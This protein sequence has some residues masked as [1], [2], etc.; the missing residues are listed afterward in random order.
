MLIRL[1]GGRVIDPASGRDGIGDIWIRGDRIVAPP[2]GETP[3]EVYD[4]SGKI[5]MAGAID[6]HSHVAERKCEHRPAAA[7]GKPSR[8]YR[9]APRQRRCRRRAGRLSRPAAAMPRWA[10]RPSS[11]RPFR[12]ITRC[13]RISNSPTF[14][15][16]TRA[17]LT[18]LGEDDFLLSLM[19]DGQEPHGHRGLSRRDARGKQGP[20]HQG[21]QSW[22]VGRLS[23]QCAHLR[24]RRCRAEL[25]RHIAADLRGFAAGGD[26]YRH[27]AS[28]ASSHQQSRRSPAMS[29][30]RSRPSP[31]P[32]A[33]RCISPICS[34]I[35]MARRASA[36][37][38]PRPRASRR[39]SMRLRK[40]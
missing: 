33:S 2:Q 40:R 23:E 32:A 36:A 39:R 35:P 4:V 7:A 27:S 38:L 14:R 8:P 12:R 1:A 9:R 6:I 34:S 5:V 37:F 15:S 21:D 17:I 19:R 22:R 30:P 24:P 28:A 25:R 20:R 16:S 29:R 13:I 3:D 10:S 26:R 18:V 31:R 11:S